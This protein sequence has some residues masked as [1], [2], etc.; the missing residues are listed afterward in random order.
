MK[1]IKQIPLH[2]YWIDFSDLY[3]RADDI[4]HAYQSNNL[5]F[6]LGSGASKYYVQEMPDWRQLL[7][8]LMSE[9]QP[10]KE[11]QRS[12]IRQLIEKQRYLLAAEAIKQY[13]IST[14]DNHNL[15]VDKAISGILSQR[16]NRSQKKSIVTFCYFGFLCS[17]CYHKF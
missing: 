1:T 11:W 2:P 13:A 6:F 10:E 7:E 14:M 16:L 15:A 12:E 4:A 17:H 3:R 8:A 5:V 9:L